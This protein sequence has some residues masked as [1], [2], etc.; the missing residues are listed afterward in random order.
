MTNRKRAE[1]NKVVNFAKTFLNTEVTYSK[2]K[3]NNSTD[4]VT[5]TEGKLPELY[6]NSN[7]LSGYK[8]SLGNIYFYNRQG[9]DNKFLHG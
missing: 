5:I 8:D 3:K 1:V 4:G 6:Q 7:C 9:N 2:K